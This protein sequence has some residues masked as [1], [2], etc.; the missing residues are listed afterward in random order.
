MHL[1]SRP[2]RT[3]RFHEWSAGKAVTFIVTLAATQ[4]VTLAARE[5][6]MSRKSAYALKARDSAFAAAWAAAVNAGAKVS[7]EG[8]KVNEVDEAR[9][10]SGRGDTSPS[11]S[12]RER[13]F[14]RLLSILRES[15]PLAP[16][17]PA[18]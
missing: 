4:S 3:H 18:Q 6:G 11:R 12:E 1:L 9:V 17:A 14:V 8:D 15:G 2:R 10:S 5:A 13:D 7:R 16:S